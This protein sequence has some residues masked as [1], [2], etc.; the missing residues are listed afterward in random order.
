MTL[1]STCH[2]IEA[3]LIIF[4]NKKIKIRSDHLYVCF[5]VLRLYLFLD[6]TLQ[7]Y[8]DLTPAFRKAIVCLFLVAEEAI[9]LCYGCLDQIM[10]LY[11]SIKLHLKKS[12]FIVFLIVHVI[13]I[14]ILLHFYLSKIF[15]QNIY[16][17]P[18][19]YSRM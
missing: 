7:V 9:G 4:F 5:S 1:A 8:L 11:I 2:V 13:L 12:I 18:S 15:K 10:L 14:D 3:D 17:L 19:I 6:T 16:L